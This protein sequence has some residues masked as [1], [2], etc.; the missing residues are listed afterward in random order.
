M[1]VCGVCLFF[2]IFFINVFYIL[3]RLLIGILKECILNI[4]YVFDNVNKFF[5]GSLLIV[6]FNMFS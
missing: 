2:L 3:R 4:C 6:F 5:R 1:C